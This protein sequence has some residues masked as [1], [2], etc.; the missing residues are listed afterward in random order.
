MYKILW[1]EPQ[2]ACVITKLT[3]KMYIIIGN[4]FSF[5]ILSQSFSTQNYIILCFSTCSSDLLYSG[6]KHETN[7]KRK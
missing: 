6:N 1:N 3:E 7:K 5:A 4:L 2:Y